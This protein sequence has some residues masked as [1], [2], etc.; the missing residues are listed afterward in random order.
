M[1]QERPDSTTDRKMLSALFS[2]PANA[3]PVAPARIAVPSATIDPVNSIECLLVF[4]GEIIVRPAFEGK[5]P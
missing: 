1:H 5:A 3:M 4:M 2:Q